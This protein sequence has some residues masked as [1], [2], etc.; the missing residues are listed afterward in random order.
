MQI[1]RNVKTEKQLLKVGSVETK[2]LHFLEFFQ[3]QQ[4]PH[5]MIS[6]QPSQ[7]S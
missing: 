5:T 6:K 3:S 2:S 1:R 7:A 4:P